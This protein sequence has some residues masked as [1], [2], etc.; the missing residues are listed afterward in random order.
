MGQHQST[1]VIYTCDSCGKEEE[2]ESL[3]GLSP[4][5]P[6][7]WMGVN[8]S[9]PDHDMFCSWKCLGDYAH[10]RHEER[11][12]KMEKTKAGASG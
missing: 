11:R 6:P 1:V 10:K 3:T 7:G 8:P 12:A 5:F 2:I 9:R 4:G